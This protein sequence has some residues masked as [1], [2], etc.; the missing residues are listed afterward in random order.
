MNAIGFSE[1]EA[2]LM[3]MPTPIDDPHTY[4]RTIVLVRHVD[5]LPEELRDPFVDRVLSLCGE[6]F[7]L[8]YVR[9]N[10]VASR[11]A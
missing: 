1:A 9:L 6:P 2:W 10:M 8:D 5:K 3:N 11:P 7:V 4:A